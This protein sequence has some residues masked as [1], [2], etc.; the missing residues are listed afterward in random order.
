MAKHRAESKTAVRNVA[1][2]VAAGAGIATMSAGAAQAAPVSVPS[3]DV[4]VD[5][6]APLVPHV[7]PHLDRAGNLVQKYNVAGQA[8]VPKAS[9]NATAKKAAPKSANKSLGQKIADAAQ[10]KI[11]APYAWGAAGPSAFDCSGL[12]SW[13]Y[14]QVG[15]AI[16]RTSQAQAGNGTPVAISNLQPGD[17]VS[18]YGGAS[19]VAIYIGNGKVVHALNDSVPVQVNDLNYLPINN[20]VRF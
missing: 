19:H 6:P 14:Q 15:K 20:A 8:A 17:I 5:V 12:T 18:Y 13:A 2:M 10:S 9:Q 7:K 16:P 3:T 11:G 1:F 4:T